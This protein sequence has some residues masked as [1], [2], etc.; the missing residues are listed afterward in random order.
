MKKNQIRILF[1]FI[2]KIL[3]ENFDL[4]KSYNYFNNFRERK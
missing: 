3:I 2:L 4:E 1:E